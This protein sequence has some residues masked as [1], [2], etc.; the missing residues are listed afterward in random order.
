MKKR[1][2]FAIQVMIFTLLAVLCG[3]GSSDRS[4]ANG[5]ALPTG[6][7]AQSIERPAASG[8]IAEATEES[9]AAD[10]GATAE[11]GEETVMFYA[12]VE[13]RVLTILPENNSSAEA[14]LN[15]LAKGDVTVKMHDYGNF[16]KVGSL[17]TS[18]PT[19]DQSITTVPGDVILYQGNQIT[20][21]YDTNTWSFTRL[22]RV[23]GMTQAELREA[24]G[25]DPTVV[26]SL[27]N[28]PR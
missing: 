23:Q 26:F 19:N 9:T 2:V 16:E 25:E 5:T 11:E 14:F 1:R 20:I 8:T 28:S 27:Q 18:L 4:R 7:A 10:A 12:H 3:C 24:L 17:G 6:T 21:Y 13:G 22:G 15:L